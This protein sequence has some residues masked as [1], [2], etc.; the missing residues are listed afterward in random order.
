M[1]LTVS[2]ARDLARSVMEALGHERGEAELVADHLIDC[3]LRGLAYGGLAR[4]LSIAERLARSGD[5][6]RPLAIERETPVSARIDGGDRI[7]YLVAERA[8]RLAIDKALASGIAVVG[9]HDTWYTGMLSYYAER[10]AAEGLVTMIAS[11]ASPWVAPAGGSEGRF[12]TNPICF[13]FPSTGDPF[14]WDIGTSEIIHAQ[15]VLAGRLGHGLPEGVAFDPEGRPTRDPAAALAGCFAP[16]GGHKGAGLGL[17]VQLL[18]VLA[19]SPLQPPELAGFGFLIVALRP[20]LL[21]DE[22]A[23]RRQVADYAELLRGTRPLEPGGHVRVPF[24]R[25]A[26]ERRRRLAEDAIELPE[27][28]YRQLT[29]IAAGTAPP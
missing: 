15:V 4:A 18:G 21:G 24:E 7:G 17:V 2:Q 13:G 23:F 22:A 5:R 6:R 9:A 19:G 20:G 10:A 25:S 28:L 27:P 29:E 8:T 26:A 14:I 16:W 12:G 3:E 1:R 11:N